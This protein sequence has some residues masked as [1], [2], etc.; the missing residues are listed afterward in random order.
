MKINFHKNLYEGWR[1]WKIDYD[2]FVSYKVLLY[3]KYVIIHPSCVCES[4]INMTKLSTKFILELLL[5]IYQCQILL[6]KKII[7]EKNYIYKAILF[8]ISVRIIFITL[9]FANLILS[10]A[11]WA[12]H[13]FSEMETL[14]KYKKC[15][16]FTQC[17]L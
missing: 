15:Q 16:L 8:S 10:N 2:N 6:Y 3:I 4:V 13:I 7:Q 14:Q 12:R 1:V 11:Y 5:Y 17:L 9:Y